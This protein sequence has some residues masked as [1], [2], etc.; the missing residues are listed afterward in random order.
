[1]HL[2]TKNAHRLHADS[3]VSFSLIKLTKF[4]LSHHDKVLCHRKQEKNDKS[5]RMCR[6]VREEGVLD[7]SPSLQNKTKII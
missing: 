6:H 1:M 3:L 4:S 7:A 2:Q 5:K